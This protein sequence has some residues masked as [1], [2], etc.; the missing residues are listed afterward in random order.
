M[1]FGSPVIELMKTLYASR[2][3]SARAGLRQ[4]SVVHEAIA[5]VWR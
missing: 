5:A 4:A 2:A 1:V 3:E